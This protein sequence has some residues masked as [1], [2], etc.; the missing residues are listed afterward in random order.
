VQFVAAENEVDNPIE[1]TKFD[2]DDLSADEEGENM[3]LD[4][5]KLDPTRPWTVRPRGKECPQWTIV[6]GSTPLGLDVNMH[7]GRALHMTILHI[8]ND[9]TLWNFNT[10]NPD[11]AVYPGDRIIAVNNEWTDVVEMFAKMTEPSSTEISLTVERGLRKK[12]EGVTQEGI[13]LVRT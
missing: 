12:E 4:I 2:L 1:A 3:R 8:K 13:L 10:S 7:A 5:A 9:G 6:L 11:K